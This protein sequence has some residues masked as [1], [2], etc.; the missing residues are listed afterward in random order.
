MNVGVS[1]ILVSVLV[2]VRR[3]AR[4]RAI[5]DRR[6]VVDELPD[7]TDLLVAALRSGLTPVQSVRVVAPLVPG[8][9]RPDFIRVL[10][11]LDEGDRFV[12]AVRGSEHARELFDVLA[13]GER[14][15]VPIDHLAFQLALDA[16]DR[17]RR[18][19]DTDARRLPV[20][21][22]VPLVVCTLPSFVVL[23]IVPVIVDTLGHLGPIT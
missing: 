9:L 13:D 6:R 22:A 12:D 3:R 14:L 17:R 19:A 21:L 23:V 11:R 15:G 7:A 10:D 5:H 18:A 2:F 8:S 1:V 16:R 20:R 4:R